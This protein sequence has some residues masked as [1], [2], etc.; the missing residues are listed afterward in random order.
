MQRS[1]EEEARRPDKEEDEDEA[2][3]EEGLTVE[4]DG[5]EEAAAEILEAA[6]EMEEDKDSKGEE[7]VSVNLRALRAIEFL[8]QE[9]EPSGT[10]LVDACNGFK[11]LSRFV[12][13]WTV[14]HLWSEGARFLFNCY[15]YW[16]Q[17]LLHQL[18]EPPV[19][20]LS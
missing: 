8:T 4:T 17:I 13:L 10:M 7:V 20:I 6:L 1:I 2:T 9:V 16:A 3:R 12:I 14:Q 18:G 15:R 5:T 19:T 11:Y